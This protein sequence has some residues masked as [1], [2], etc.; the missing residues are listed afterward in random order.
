LSSI[1]ERG[2]KSPNNVLAMDLLSA[3]GLFA[4]TVMV[5]SYALHRWR[6]T[7]EAVRERVRHD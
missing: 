5:V 7:I 3:L 6:H 2:V 1:V 4:M